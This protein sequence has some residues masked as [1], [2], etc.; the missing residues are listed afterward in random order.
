MKAHIGPIG[1]ALREA[2][3]EGYDRATLRSD[4]MAGLVVGVVALPLSM[5]LA[6]ASGVPPAH[7]L[8]TAVVAGAVAALAGGSRV[9]VTGPTAAFVVLLAPIAAK[10][11]V[12]GLA[13]A[14]LMAGGVLLLMGIGHLGRLI[15]F[16]P[17]TVVTG[18]TAGIAVVI[19][20]L[21]VPDA[22]GLT[23][24]PLPE[25]T[26]DK[27]MA[28]AAALPTLRAPDVAIA[29]LTLAV[30]LLWPRVTH[31]VPSPLVALTVA[32][33]A[34][35][36]AVAVVPGLEIATI[37]T[38]F[39]AIPAALPP[40]GVPWD[41]PGPGGARLELSWT[42]IRELA[43]SA[44]AIAMLGAIESLLCAVA[45]DGLTGRRHDPDA[46]L[47]GQG[48]ANLVAP[49]FGGIAAT[50]AIARTATNVRAGG[51]SPIAAITHSAV[52]LAAMIAL[53]PALSLL[54][55]ASLA[56]L[57]LLVAWNMSD[58]PHFA[59]ILTRAPRS[60]VFV[61]L[62]C[63]SLTIAFDMVLSVSVGVVLASLMFMRRMAEVSDVR[64]IERDEVEGDLKL[65]PDVAV[66]AV[67]G[68]LFFGVAEKAVT[69]L[70]QVSDATRHTILDL[71]RVP[72]IDA[73]A[74][75]NLESL[76]RK[77]GRRHVE[78]TLVGVQPQ[79]ERVL[80]RAG[81][82]DTPGMGVRFARSVREAIT[83]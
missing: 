69:A 48:L 35:A 53:A 71:S 65:P 6:I 1:A 51:T 49:F 16:V 8:F 38:R 66:Y 17:T 37:G 10:Y 50:G 80:R 77:L 2:L 68:P 62:T 3:A 36:I 23:V 31:K 4:V 76:V 27:A 74:L 14:S 5:A 73:T 64:L 12:A 40:L 79:P 26:L 19:A 24:G 42:L 75:V 47:M 11:G 56:G 83:P 45:A 25:H 39:G 57:L 13:L 22:L 41:L 7:G 70:E 32:T 44:F 81:W 82:Y 20:L 21:Q 29:A 15:Q 9:A 67:N 54:P 59:R 34:A 18:F 55:M 60:D 33:I 58:L 61:L 43:P 78:I 72:A 30:L 46:E 28:I 63:F 52:V